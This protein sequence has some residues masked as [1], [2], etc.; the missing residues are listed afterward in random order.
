M[1]KAERQLSRIRIIVSSSLL[2]T[3]LLVLLLST[4][5][6]T[7]VPER[8]GLA[9]LSFFQRGFSAVSS[10]V[11]QSVTSISELRILEQKY[12]ELLSSTEQL[13]RMERDFDR[14]NQENITLKQQLG[15]S[16]E[17]TYKNIPAKIIGKDPGNVYSTFILDKGL[18]EGIKKND[19]VI[20]YQDGIEGLVGRVIEV[21]RYSCLVLP[22]FD[23]SAYIAIRLQ[24][25]RYEGLAVG[26]GNESQNLIVK[27]IKKRALE[28]I[29]LGDIVITSGLQSLYPP[30]IMVGRIRRIHELPYLTSIEFDLDP[31]VD[32]DRLEYVFILTG[33][34]EVLNTMQEGK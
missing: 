11:S 2:F 29:N 5:S 18:N 19:I 23:A 13:R 15:F 24:E 9:V 30:D 20:A 10:F 28:Q 27:Y 6:L 14:I 33:V 21:S 8:V 22:I 7:G 31:V 4:R 17:L 1:K 12:N 34:T 32:F 3:S 26:S 25:S 16:T